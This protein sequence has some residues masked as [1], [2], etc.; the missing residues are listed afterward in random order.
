VFPH[1]AG[2]VQLVPLLAGD[3]LESA[4]FVH[5]PGADVRGV[6]RQPDPLEV[7]FGGQVD[8]GA[9]QLGADADVL[10]ARAD[11]DQHLALPRVDGEQG[12][13]S[14]DGGVAGGGHEV[15][16]RGE[17]LLHPFRADLVLDRRKPLE[18]IPRLEGQ[19]HRQQ[20]PLGLDRQYP[21]LDLLTIL[22]GELSRQAAERGDW[23]GEIHG[24]TPTTVAGQVSYHFRPPAG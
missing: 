22:A 11:D 12:G 15:D 17:H 1:L 2:H 10:E 8:A 14:D 18:A 21:H 7:Q 6:D 20:L 16:A 4:F 9:H 13:V 5:V 3:V 19:I 24:G 23:H